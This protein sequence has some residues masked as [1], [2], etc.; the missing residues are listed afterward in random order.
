[1]WSDV[2][3]VVRD[4]GLDNDRNGGTFTVAFKPFS[5]LTT[6]QFLYMG[7]TPV[8]LFRVG[9]YLVVVEW[10]FQFI[11]TCFGFFISSN[12]VLQSVMLTS[13]W[14]DM[15]NFQS[16][17]A[18]TSFCEG[19][20]TLFGPPV[21]GMLVLVIVFSS[22]PRYATLPRIS[23][24]NEYLSIFSDRSTLINLGVP[25]VVNYETTPV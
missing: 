5:F 19:I 3:Y 7:G 16:S 12:Y 11:C 22:F 13:M 9:L 20:A 15:R 18:L 10:L 1:M 17:Y 25:S 21:I 2:V 14:E 23:D 24:G 4:D 8:W 6:L